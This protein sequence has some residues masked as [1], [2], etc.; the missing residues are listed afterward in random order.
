MAL[1]KPLVLK[2]GIPQQLPAGDAVVAPTRLVSV[3]MADGVTLRQVTVGSAGPAMVVFASGVSAEVAGENA[4]VWLLTQDPPLP[5]TPD[6][7]DITGKLDVDFSGFT[8]GVTPQVTDIWAIRRGSSTFKLTVQALLTW[9][10]G[11]ARTWLGV[12]TFSAGAVIGEQSPVVKCKVIDTTMT[13]STSNTDLVAHGL[14][15]A[16]ILSASGSVLTS[17]GVWV[18]MNSS[19][20]D[21]QWAFTVNATHIRALVTSASSASVSGR[22]ARFHIFYKG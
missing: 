22:P 2:G 21:A 20:G 5:V 17:T 3:R 11:S 16:D 13:S 18:G 15:Q 19:Y 6:P 14:V 4:A 12:Q 7:V 10:L 9:L 8:D 1:R